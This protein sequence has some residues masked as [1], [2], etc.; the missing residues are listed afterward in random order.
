VNKAD[1]GRYLEDRYY[2]QMDWYSKK[3]SH[4]QKGYQGLQTLVIIFSIMTPTIIIIGVGWLRWLAVI[5]SGIVAVGATLLKAF[6]FHE[7]WINYRTTR[8]T[9][10]KE[11]H[12]YNARLFGYREAEDPEALFVERV[13]A[14]ISRENTLWIYV[15][16]AKEEKTQN[17]HRRT[18]P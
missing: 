4:C 7:N 12:Y 17:S 15:Q 5:S 9:L 16:K 14:V 3:A 6:K 18:N 8:E 1:F 10:R 13:E 11:I 2:K